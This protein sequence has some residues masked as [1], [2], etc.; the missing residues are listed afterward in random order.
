MQLCGLAGPLLEETGG[1]TTA[2]IGRFEV[3]PGH[4]LIWSEAITP[5]PRYSGSVLEMV[6]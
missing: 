5:N 6:L 4:N 2:E 1:A 3:P